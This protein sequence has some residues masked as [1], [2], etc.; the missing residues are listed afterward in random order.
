[1]SEKE[2]IRIEEGN[3]IQRFNNLLFL[4]LSNWWK[5]KSWI[6]MAL[7]WTVISPGF[8]LLTLIAVPE[9]NL[10][11]GLTLFSLMLGFFTAIATVLSVQ[12]SIIGEQRTE[13]VS[14]LLSK[15]ITRQSFILVKFISNS[16]NLLIPIIIIPSMIAYLELSLILSVEIPILPFM[17]AV[18][19]LCLIQLFFIGFTIMMGTIQDSPGSVAAAPIIYNF[20]Q[21]FL[22]S[23]PF[24]VNF[25]P[26]TFILPPEGQNS[27]VVALIL[28][29]NV[30]IFLPLFSTIT[31]SILFVFLAIWLFQRQEL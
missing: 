7:L 8:T 29:E 4:E 23:I 10:E 2:L 21:Q 12:D 26:V 25:L 31:I 20:A 28:G 17:G 15:P 14:W 27:I 3:I 9:A 30:D 24:L 22:A 5:S 19:I 6:S 18:A 1:M 16:I 13:T 11:L